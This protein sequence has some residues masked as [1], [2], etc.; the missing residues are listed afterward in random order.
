MYL[1]FVGKIPHEGSQIVLAIQ[2]NNSNKSFSLRVNE[3]NIDF[4]LKHTQTCCFQIAKQLIYTS[5]REH[6]AKQVTTLCLTRLSMFFNTK[7]H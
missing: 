6:S 7:L 4:S 2:A 3:E 1:F 5:I